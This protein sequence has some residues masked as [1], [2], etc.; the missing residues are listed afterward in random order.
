[1]L[2]LRRFEG[3]EEV[4]QDLGEPLRLL[5]WQEVASARQHSQLAARNGFVCL[6]GMGDRYD[7]ILFAPDDESGYAGGQVEP[8]VGADPL[9]GQVDH[10]TNGMDKG[11][12]GGPVTK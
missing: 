12:L 4:K 2:D 5:E 8:V 9:A 11:L 1:M 3:F 6:M 7:A 10:R